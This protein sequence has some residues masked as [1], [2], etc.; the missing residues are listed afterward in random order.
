[1]YQLVFIRWVLISLYTLKITGKEKFFGK[2]VEEEGQLVEL[3]GDQNPSP[4]APPRGRRG[5]SKGDVRRGETSR[6]A[7]E[8]SWCLR[9]IER[10]EVDPIEYFFSTRSEEP[11]PSHRK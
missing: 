10:K 5:G 3:V 6:G 7:M 4:E 8:K 2:R 9:V 1:M 11:F